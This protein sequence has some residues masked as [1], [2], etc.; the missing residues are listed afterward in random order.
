MEFC[1]AGEHVGRGASGAGTEKDHP[2]RF[3]QNAHGE[4]NGIEE[5]RIENGMKQEKRSIKKEV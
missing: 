5:G 1:I 2:G 4:Y 3:C